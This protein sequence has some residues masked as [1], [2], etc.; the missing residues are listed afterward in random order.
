MRTRIFNKMTQQEV[1]DYLDRGGDTIFIAVGVVECH[2]DMP[3]DCES[4]YPE[5]MAV[6][7]AEKADG[8]AMINLPYFYPGGTVI[9]NA[10]VHMSIRESIDYLM[11]IGHSLVDQG[12]KRIFLT[13]GHA[14]ASLYI[15]VFCRDFFE[16]TL[17]HPCHIASLTGPMVWPAPGSKV[18][19]G[20]MLRKGSAKFYGAYKVMGMMDY[21]PVNPDGAAEAEHLPEVPSMKKF[22]ALARSFGGIASLVFSDPKQH[23]GGQIFASEE[24]RLAVCTEGEKYLLEEVENCKICE[25]KEALGEYQD[26]VQRVYAAN[27][28]IRNTKK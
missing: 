26:Y 21:L 3:I 2:G 25:L 24:E 12:F 9:G 19:M 17:I 5:A 8:L 16:E 7:L 20:E 27:P 22:A 10:T 4:T 11:K 1:Q 6:L 14:P 23:A 13:S 15:N 28:R 18:D